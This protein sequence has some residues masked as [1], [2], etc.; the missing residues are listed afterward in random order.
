MNRPI[1]NRFY[2]DFGKSKLFPE[3]PHNPPMNQ[4]FP[5]SPKISNLILNEPIEEF[6][7]EEDQ[8]E[9]LKDFLLN[10]PQRKGSIVSQFLN[11]KNNSNNL[12]EASPHQFEYP[13][14]GKKMGGGKNDMFGECADVDMREND[15]ESIDS[16]E[17][18]IETNK[19]KDQ[20]KLTES[21]TNINDT[22][23]N[24]LNYKFGNIRKDDFN[25]D[26]EFLDEFENVSMKCLDDTTNER[27]NHPN[28]TVYQNQPTH[29][30]ILLKR[31]Y[32]IFIEDEDKDKTTQM[33]FNLSSCKPQMDKMQNHNDNYQYE[34]NNPFLADVR[35]NNI[36]C[37]KELNKEVNHFQGIVK[38]LLNVN[39][40]IS[41]NM[42]SMNGVK[43]RE[44]LMQGNEQGILMRN[45][46]KSFNCSMLSSRP[47]LGFMRNC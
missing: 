41:N 10:A 35:N 37:E 30:S 19:L 33:K 7:L 8:G 32:Q 1:R 9:S 11:S 5:E 43:K 28:M 4:Y 40:G 20:S 25:Y 14:G 31:D 27:V 22:A 46:S 18:E 24:I 21:S 29:N 38:H 39:K 16:F 13:L 26:N 6:N 3:T 2:S 36:D 23:H 42:Y 15:N 12:H 44:S 17:I 45:R 34:Q 47:I